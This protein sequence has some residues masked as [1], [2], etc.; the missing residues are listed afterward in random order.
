VIGAAIW[1]GVAYW[2]NYEIGWIAWAVGL[3]VGVGVYLGTRRTGGAAAGGLAVGIAIAS[4]LGARY[5]FVELDLRDAVMQEHGSIP[6]QVPPTSDRDFWIRYLADRLVEEREA[7]GQTVQWPEGSSFETAQEE[8]DY[9]KEIWNDAVQRWD[10]LSSADQV[11][12]RDSV[13]PAIQ[14]DL[15]AFVQVEHDA[16][17]SEGFLSTFALI[18]IIFAALAIATA[19]KVGSGNGQHEEGNTA[20]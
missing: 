8:A 13:I 6:D 2:A 12:Y 4:I 19:Y 18:D 20:S 9:P 5:A 16:M 1:T 10:Y 15:L 11:N 3:L 7:A 14:A 17:I